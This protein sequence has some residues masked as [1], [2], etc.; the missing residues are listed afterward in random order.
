MSASI[1]EARSAAADFDFIH[2]NWRVDHRKLLR[3]LAGSTEWQAFPGTVRARPILGGFGNFDENVLEDPTGTYHAATIRTFDP[4]S[5]RWTIHWIDG[6]DPSLDAPVAGSFVDGVG[7]F[8]GED[9][10][11]TRPILVRFVWSEITA[12]SARWE[13]AFSDDAGRSWEVNWVMH[14]HRAPPSQARR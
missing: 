12:N 8:L 11:E 5:G 2:G 4:A 7:T 6:R 1:T 13:Q 9:V 3:R 10:L 14:F